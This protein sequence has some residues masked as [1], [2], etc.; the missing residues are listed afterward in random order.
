MLH[1]TPCRA[2]PTGPGRAASARAASARAGL[3]RELESGAPL[4]Q[5]ELHYQPILSL[6]T[7][8]VVGAEA[9]V[10]WDR[11]GTLVPAADFIA[12]ADRSGRTRAIELWSLERALGDLVG[13]RAGG[14]DGWLALNLS[15]ATL[16][17]PGLVDIARRRLDATG[18][19]AAA[20]VFEVTE[21][22]TI[23]GN[24]PAAR[25]LDGLRGLG[26]RV[27]VDDFGT[28]YAGLEFLRDYD[29]DLIKLDR[30]FVA[31][32]RD[33]RADRILGPLVELA[34][35]LGKPV[36]AE[37]VER[38]GDLRRSVGAG[39]EMAQGYLLGRP[40]PAATFR[41]RHVGPVASR[42]TA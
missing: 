33:A 3:L 9:L 25:A 35:R 39:C 32:G 7:G 31:A 26:A 28:G 29:P 1:T 40:V 6:A 24:G 36:I 13:W 11:S 18:T 15:A 4:S 12:L 23:A 16:A 2:G 37:G 27:A 8:A 42:R 14:W 34:H 30:G 10:R 19:P 17:G 41:D 21:R 38:P 20:L 22:T 5:L